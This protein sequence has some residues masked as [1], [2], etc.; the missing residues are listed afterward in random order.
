[1]NSR[2]YTS[3]S[4]VWLSWYDAR[5]RCL[6]NGGDLASFDFITQ[7]QDL[8]LLNGSWLTPN[9]NY[10]LGLRQEWWT[11]QGTR[12]YGEP[13]SLYVIK[14]LGLRIYTPTLFNVS[15]IWQLNETCT[16]FSQR[17]FL[18]RIDLIIIIQIMA[19]FGILT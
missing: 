10:W 2:C 11:W 6:A 14:I 15:Y 1:M 17:L 7:N 4:N 9:Y 3:Y 8:R 19:L 13:R 16:A 5:S 18:K 12:T